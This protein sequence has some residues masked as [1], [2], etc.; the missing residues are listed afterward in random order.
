MFLREGFILNIYCGIDFGTTN[1]VVSI[2]GK[3]GQ[4]VDLL[5]LPT[6]L[7][8][9]SERHKVSCVYIGDE[10]LT[11]FKR[12]QSGR[13]I[14]SIKRSLSDSSFTKT[15][16]NNIYFTIEEI[17]SLF[18]VE[19]KKT[20]YTKWGID[21]IKVVIGKPV[22]FSDIKEDDKVALTR[23]KKGFKLAGF[24]ETI[25]LEEPIAASY[26]FEHVLKDKDNHFLIL[27]YGGGTSDYSL[28]SHDK[29]KK[30]IDK[31][32]VIK[33]EGVDGGG[34]HF[35]EILMLN[36]ICPLLGKKATYESYGKRL[37]IPAHIF[38]QIC[39]WN[40]FKVKNKN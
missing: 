25:V 40:N 1:T 35:D 32:K 30:G 22:K 21:P 2:A 33:L 5:S 34:D 31:Y 11:A 37:E 13:Y 7:F 14:H 10:A 19:L 8:I 17:L 39:Q 9:P 38:N 18:L 24:K 6:A 16:I 27:D 28:I 29:N 3:N 36:L 4:V 23:L 15:R 12:K 20:I 26:C